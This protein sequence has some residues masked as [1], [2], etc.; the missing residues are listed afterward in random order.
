[1]IAI[2]CLLNNFVSYKPNL[3]KTPVCELRGPFKESESPTE[4]PGASPKL[5][6]PVPDLKRPV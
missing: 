4:V 1:M 6:K 3:Q 2:G 5:N